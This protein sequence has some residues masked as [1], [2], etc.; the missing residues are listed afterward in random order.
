MESKEKII[1]ECEQKIRITDKAKMQRTLQINKAQPGSISCHFERIVTPK[2][3]EIRPIS[4]AIANKFVE[5][6]HRHHTKVPGHKFSIGCYLASELVGVAVVGRPVSRKL[7]NGLTAEVTRLCTDGTKNAA[8]KL[9]SACWRIAKEMGYKKIITY[10]LASE[11]GI[12]LKASGWECEA[13]KCGG[14]YWNSSANRERTDKITNLF[15]E[16]KK[17]PNEYKKRYAKSFSG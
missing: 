16:V 14:L 2:T 1:E 10:I 11:K 17:Y 7:D 6:N 4:L 3:L 9:Y 13:E 12:S 8:S 15:G 5:E